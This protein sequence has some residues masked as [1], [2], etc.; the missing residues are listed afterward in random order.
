MHQK[1]DDSSKGSSNFEIL[2]INLDSRTDR[3]TVIEE[4]IKEVAP[5]IPVRRLSA[6]VGDDRESSITKPELGAFLSHFEAIKSINE[7][8]LTLILED[9]AILCSN[10]Y[11]MING[12]LGH[13]VEKKEWDIL[14]LS[15]MIDISNVK[16]IYRVLNT[17]SQMKAE[18]AHL[19]KIS[20]MDCRSIYASGA[21]AYIVNP[22]SAKKILMHLREF[23]GARY[24]LPIDL[25]YKSLID[26][27]SIVGRFTV[28][29]L[30]GL[31]G[32][33]DSS[34]QIHGKITLHDM[35]EDLSNLIYIEGDIEYLLGK[36]KST[37]ILDEDSKAKFIACQILFGRMIMK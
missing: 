29:Y 16:A 27:K 8:R 25:C 12:L 23:E 1:P 18:N 6:L 13:M 9:D 17:K 26:D 14:F 15:Q 5:N 28:P 34:I 2:Y 20:I 3:R 19:R 24:P 10:F 37:P 35:L 11:E 4:R 22:I 31:I 7:Q 30:T 21:S 32:A 36:Y 33:N